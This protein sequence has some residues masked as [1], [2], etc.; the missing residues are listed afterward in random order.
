MP[1][2]GPADDPPSALRTTPAAPP[3]PDAPRVKATNR[4]GDRTSNVG[5]SSTNAAG[6]GPKTT[7]SPDSTIAD[8]PDGRAR[9]SSASNLKGRGE[10]GGRPPARGRLVRGDRER[11]WMAI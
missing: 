10:R 3:E 5:K 6:A 2:A 1:A 11:K 7:D 4:A 8:I 9:S